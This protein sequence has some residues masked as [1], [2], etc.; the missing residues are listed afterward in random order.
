M[1]F[2]YSLLTAP[3]VVVHEIGHLFFCLLSGVKIYKIKLFQFN[4]TVAGFV[5]HE[6]PRYFIQ[7]VLISFGPLMVN[8]LLTLFL[9]A[10]LTP[11]YPAWFTSIWTGHDL[12]LL[13]LWLAIAVGLHA[14]PSTG[15]AKSL[16]QTTNGR[17]L[18]NP[19]I[20]IG[21]P[22]VLLL[23]ILNLLKRIHFDFVYVAIL[24]WLGR[25]YLKV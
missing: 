8:T 4:K 5:E 24:F 7:A 1:F 16:L 25:F 19:L 17:V 13:W 15:D 18:K 22:F 9:F 10:K 2:L 11:N 21:Y 12:S 20:L 3:G 6:E 14:I 23:Y